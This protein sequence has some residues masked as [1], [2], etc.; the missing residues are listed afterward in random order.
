MLHCRLD[1]IEWGAHLLEGW[2]WMIS[3]YS[4]LSSSAPRR[5]TAGPTARPPRSNSAYTTFS[6]SAFRAGW[7]CTSTF[8]IWKYR[9]QYR[10]NHTNNFKAKMISPVFWFMKS[11]CLDY[12]ELNFKSS[13]ISGCFPLAACCY[14][15]KI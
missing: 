12:S 10:S 7:A 4:V 6:P 5:T 3:A 15:K 2:V 1:Y 9:Y 13:I 8:S 11:Q 14:S